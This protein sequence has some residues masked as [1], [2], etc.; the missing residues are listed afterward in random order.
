[1][2]ADGGKARGCKTERMKSP[3][4]EWQ[5]PDL[6]HQAVRMVLLPCDRAA[7]RMSGEGRQR[8]RCFLSVFVGRR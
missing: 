7:V 5:V 4:W 2:P 8:A 1:M 3:E 6:A